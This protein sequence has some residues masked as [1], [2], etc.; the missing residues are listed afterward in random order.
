MSL[1]LALYKKNPDAIFPTPSAFTAFLPFPDPKISEVKYT[2]TALYVWQWGATTDKAIINT[3][4]GSFLV[5]G[6]APDTVEKYLLANIA[7]SE[8]I[9]CDSVPTSCSAVFVTNSQLFSYVSIS[10]CEIAYYVETDDFIC[11]SNRIGPL[12]SFLLLRIRPEAIMQMAGRYLV[13]DDGTMFFGIKKLLNGQRLTC[14]DNKYSIE[15]LNYDS[16]W[17]S[18]SLTDALDTLDGMLDNYRPIA[19][20]QYNKILSLSGGKDS[21]A[22]LSILDSIGCVDRSFTATTGGFPFSPEVL[23]AQEVMER[24]R[25]RQ[26]THSLRYSFD[27]DAS[28]K[29]SLSLARAMYT[30][31]VQ[32]GLDILGSPIKGPE[33]RFGGHEFGFKA[34][35]ENTNLERYLANRPRLINQKAF[36]KPDYAS[37]YLEQYNSRLR[38]IIANASPDKYWIIERIFLFMPLWHAATIMPTTIAG[39]AIHPLVD[40]ACMKALCGAPAEITTTQLGLFHLTQKNGASLA[41]VPYCVETWP[42]TLFPLL[43][44]LNIPYPDTVRTVKPY[45]YDIALPEYKRYGD[46]PARKATIQIAQNFL[47]QFIADNPGYFDFLDKEVFFNALNQPYDDMIEKNAGALPRVLAVLAGAFAIHFKDSLLRQDSQVNIASEIAGYMTNP[48][49]KRPDIQATYIQKL[50]DYAQSIAT[51]EKQKKELTDKVEKSSTWETLHSA[52]SLTSDPYSMHIS[53]GDEKRIEINGELA[54]DPDAHHTAVLMYI[55]QDG[56]N[57]TLPGLARST[58]MDVFYCYPLKSKGQSIFQLTFDIPPDVK[59]LGF[60]FLNR[61]KFKCFLVQ[62]PRISFSGKLV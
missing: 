38:K 7:G 23:A 52:I 26:C 4:N 49:E 55:T 39:T 13:T 36:I 29:L 6:Y 19:D 57:K 24:L 50:E 12:S 60:Y 14:R 28:S 56:E 32:I 35:P 2:S 5:Q 25:D 27:S 33:I 51:L 18:F 20:M 53:I 11:V 9:D 42:S 1:Y 15:E 47:P 45:L 46:L 8:S 34:G 10:G 31:E 40:R 3:E 43:D 44:K 21:R 58:Y 30:T 37:V 48:T 54:I 41:A 61:S 62:A 16:L 22:I 59:E 17:E